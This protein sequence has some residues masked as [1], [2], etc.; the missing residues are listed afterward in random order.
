MKTSVT[1]C[2]PYIDEYSGEKQNFVFE[3]KVPVASFERIQEVL[4]KQ[5]K[6]KYCASRHM[7]TF[8]S[9][10][11]LYQGLEKVAHLIAVCR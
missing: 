2:A 1:F 8:T 7:F 5:L 11:H 3:Y 4:T 9:R 10:E 6:A